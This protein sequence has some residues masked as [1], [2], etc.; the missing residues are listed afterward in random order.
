LGLETEE[1]EVGKVA[2]RFVA[3]LNQ[4]GEDEVMGL[5]VEERSVLRVLA[6]L[7]EA[8]FVHEDGRGIGTQVFYTWLHETPERWERWQATKRMIAQLLADEAYTESREATVADVPVR[9]LRV[10]TN[11]WLAEQYNRAEFGRGPAVAVQVNVGSSWLEA[12][13]EVEAVDVT[14]PPPGDEEG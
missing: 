7:G 12:L 11:K 13:R 14:P 8:G 5:Y 10:D 3:Q 1:G 4:Y 6:R 9:R 2:R